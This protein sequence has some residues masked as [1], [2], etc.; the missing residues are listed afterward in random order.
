M[1]GLPVLDLTFRDKYVP[2][3]L[4]IPADAGAPM[5][6]I[7]HSNAVPQRYVFPAQTR[8]VSLRNTG[9]NTLWL[10]LDQQTW[11]DVACGTAWDERVLTCG[12]AWDEHAL[13]RALWHCTQ[14]GTTITAVVGLT[15]MD[16]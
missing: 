8:Q 13:T 14:V 2:M 10:S 9:T 16:A 6:T 3:S 5:T 11:F 1:A 4:T 12:T 15:L 7:L